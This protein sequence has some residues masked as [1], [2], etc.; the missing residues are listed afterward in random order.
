MKIFINILL[1]TFKTIFYIKLIFLHVDGIRVQLHFPLWIVQLNQQLLLKLKKNLKFLCVYGYVSALCFPAH[2]TPVV[3]YSM[4]CI[5]IKSLDIRKC[6]SSQILLQKDLSY[7]PYS[8]P[9]HLHI[10]FGTSILISIK[11]KI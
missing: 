9:F 8:C 1:F 4:D 2:W 11:K 3:P 5:F 6:K 7:L 10:N